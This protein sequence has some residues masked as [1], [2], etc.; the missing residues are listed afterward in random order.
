L[1]A[2]RYAANRAWKQYDA[3][4]PENRLVADELEHRWN[5]AL[6]RVR[7]PQWLGIES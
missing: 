2:A 6:Q 7:E 3:T 1:E 5:Q 4:D